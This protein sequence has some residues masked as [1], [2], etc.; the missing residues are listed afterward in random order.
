VVMRFAQGHGNQES[1]IILSAFFI[2]LHVIACFLVSFI[3]LF[4]RR[5]K[6]FSGIW[7]LSGL[8]VLSIG[9][10]T[11]LGLFTIKI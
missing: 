6:G 5:W 3:C 11:C 9:F 8:L 10:S 7:L 1:G 2:A 4:V